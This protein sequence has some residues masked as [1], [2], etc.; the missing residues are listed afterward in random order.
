MRKG[1]HTE[2]SIKIKLLE[3]RNTEQE[4]KYKKLHRFCSEKF[5]QITDLC[6]CNDFNK[7]LNKTAR[8]NEIALDAFEILEQNKTELSMKL[9]KEESSR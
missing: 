6:T 9:I 3:Q 8:I 7:Q 1:K 5:K 2:E 4:D